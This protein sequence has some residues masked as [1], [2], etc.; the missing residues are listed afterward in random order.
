[1]A[2]RRRPISTGWWWVGGRIRG[3]RRYLSTRT[4]LV[5]TGGNNYVGELEHLKSFFDAQR[6]GT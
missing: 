6:A 1:M 5:R 3:V 2:G 4:L